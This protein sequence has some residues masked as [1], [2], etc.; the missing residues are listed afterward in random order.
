MS[1]FFDTVAWFMRNRFVVGFVF[2][3][4]ACQLSP[5]S[6]AELSSEFSEPTASTEVKTI[7]GIPTAQATQIPA[8]HTD[9]PEAT[10]SATET[11]EPTSTHTPTP[12]PLTTLLF[13]GVIVP[14][15]C[16]QAAIDE[17]QD[18]DYL[19]DEVREVIQQAELAIG[20][21]NAT[22]SDYPPHT[23]CVP[24]YVL[25]GGSENADALARA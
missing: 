2:L 7:E 22:I 11:P 23:G 14:A 19:F 18:S 12:I 15:R 16:V 21:L 8:I 10:I 9:T 6:T 24:T 20:T 13:T 3:L 17:Y 5:N 25:V 1:K 4:A